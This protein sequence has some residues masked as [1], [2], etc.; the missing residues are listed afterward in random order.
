M[1]TVAD[2]PGHA[3]VALPGVLLANVINLL[4]TLAINRFAFL[5]E[6]GRAHV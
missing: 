1:T 5:V 3:E 6:I 2:R 4:G